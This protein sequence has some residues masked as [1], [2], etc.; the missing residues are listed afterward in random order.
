MDVN[1]VPHWIKINAFRRLKQL[2][3]KP[4]NVPPVLQEIFDDG[5]NDANTCRVNAKTLIQSKFYK[6]KN[7]VWAF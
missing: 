6:I 3:N 2:R 4:I 7:H 1:L 5:Q